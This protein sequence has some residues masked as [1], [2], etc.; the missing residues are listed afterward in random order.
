MNKPILKINKNLS[1]RLLMQKRI[2]EILIVSSFYDAF[3]LYEDG[4]L[5]EMIIS[6]YEELDLQSKPKVVRVSTAEHAW[7]K[8]EDKKIDLIITMARISDLNPYDFGK[9]IKEKYPDIPI[10]LMTANEK[11][12]NWVQENTTDLS[13]IDKVFFWLGNSAIFP[14]IIK[15]LEDKDNANRDIQKGMVR[16]IIVVEDSPHFYSLLLPLIYKIF[17]TYTFELIKLE[18]TDDS[19][20]LRMYSRPKV[21]L[22]SNYEEAIELYEKYRDNVLTIVSDTRFPRNG[23]LDP[24]AGLKLLDNIR[25]KSFQTPMVVMSKEAQ[26][27]KQYFEELNAEFIDK[28]SASFL[29]ELEKFIVLHCG[30]GKLEFNIKDSRK[31]IKVNSLV[32]LRNVAKEITQKS[33]KTHAKNNHFSNWLAIRGYFD[34]ADLLKPMSYKDL[35]NKNI[36]F[37]Y[38]EEQLNY[39]VV[40][41][42]IIFNTRS[43]SPE[44]KYVRMGDGSLGG[45][46]RGLAFLVSLFKEYN[47]RLEYPNVKIDIPNFIVIATNHYDDFIK[48]NNLF[49]K[50]IKEKS[51][52]EID[53]LFLKSRFSR[54]FLNDI[55]HFLKENKKPLAIRSS[56]LLEDSFL[57]PFAGIYRTFMLT[58]SEDNLKERVE[59][60]SNTIKLVYASIFSKKTKSFLNS[61][62]HKREDEKMAVVVQELI[63]RQQG[64][65]FYPTF[66][67]VMQSYNYYPQKKMKRENGLATVALGLGKQVVEG[68]KSL[69]FSPYTPKVIPQFYNTKS[70]FTNTQNFFYALNLK[71]DKFPTDESENLVKLPISEAKK[72]GVMELISSVYSAHDSKFVESL[73]EKGQRVITFANILKWKAFPL[74][75]ILRDISEITRKGMGCD[76]EI[77]F[78]SNTLMNTDDVDDFSIL[79]VRPQITYDKSIALDE[80]HDEKDILIKSDICLGNGMFEN[81]YDILFIDANHFDNMQTIA[82]AQEIDK[83]NK[84]FN[85]DRKYLLI[86]PGRWGTSDRMLGIPTTWDNI[87]NVNCIVEVGIQDYFIEPSFGNHFFQN[88]TSLNIP[89]FTIPPNSKS[90]KIN[91]EWIK[92]QKQINKSNLVKH[93]KLKNPLT[94]KV[95]GKNGMGVILNN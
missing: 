6:Q 17:I 28:N 11:E 45:K 55:K 3:K 27:E 52:D 88:I 90:T 73:D 93:I 19:R 43:Y 4:R 22:A 68:K 49:K 40:D 83:L 16:T 23:E 51:D 37:Q 12:L 1:Y 70:V 15:L 89:Y 79:Q 94:I 84:K 63:G 35:E 91:C 42:M 21:L 61:V 82:Y 53:K 60:L 9:Q 85:N 25:E 26:R 80:K 69:K 13:G 34:L 20:L 29:N 64:E 59:N 72:E 58:N 75:K 95:D 5:A 14:S 54:N 46:G 86:G 44:Y 67:G 33:I 7:K 10:V 30:F 2:H 76:V 78:A 18:Y 56:S 48:R 50:I 47:F 38:I 65:Y 39:Q 32:E 31:K 74:A 77:E 24:K 87:S 8:L 66:S 81:I 36:L 62:G 57:E 41:K 92:K 71:F